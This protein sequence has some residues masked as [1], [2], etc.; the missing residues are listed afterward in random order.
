M[1]L[2]AV[3]TVYGFVVGM[4]I[5]QGIITERRLLGAQFR[6]NN[7]GELMTADWTFVLQYIMYHFHAFSFVVLLCGV[8][9]IM[10]VIFFVYHMFMVKNGCTTNEKIKYS[11]VSW[12]LEKC[13]KFY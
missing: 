13:E 7:T 4:L 9:S 8:V 12:Y 11:Q 10:L 2:H 1:F 6:N 3:I 5:F